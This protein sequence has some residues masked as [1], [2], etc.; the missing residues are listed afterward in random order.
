MRSKNKYLYC[1]RVAC[2]DLFSFEKA[3]EIFKSIYGNNIVIEFL[4]V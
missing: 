1:S 3:I 4:C 2:P